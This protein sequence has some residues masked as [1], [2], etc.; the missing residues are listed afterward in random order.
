ML[1]SEN[2]N[3][4]TA[5]VVP[6]SVCIGPNGSFPLDFLATLE[7]SICASADIRKSEAVIEEQQA[8]KLKSLSPYLPKIEVSANGNLFA[9]SVDFMSFP[10]R[11][12]KYTPT[13]AAF[14]RL[15]GAR[16]TVYRIVQFQRELHACPAV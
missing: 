13:K 3:I 12:L 8:H 4:I 2:A 9:K 5:R 11:P 10:N 6:A 7:A 1:G 16:S 14:L 15:R